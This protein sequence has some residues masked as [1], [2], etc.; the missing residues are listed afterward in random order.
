MPSNAA[1]EK[2]KKSVNALPPRQLK[3]LKR[4]KKQ[5]VHVPPPKQLKKPPETPLHLPLSL[6]LLLL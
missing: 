2:R 6:L 3:L 4:L 1:N 5:S